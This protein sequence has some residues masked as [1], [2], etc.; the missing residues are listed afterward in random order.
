[1]STVSKEDYIKTIFEYNFNGDENI[2][3][4]DL[5]ASLAI[6]KP[7]VTD[8]VKKLTRENF[9]KKDNLNQIFLT[10]KGENIATKLLRKHRLWEIFLHDVLKLKW[11]EIH[12]E[13]EKLEHSTSDKLIDKLEEFLGFPERDPHGSPIPNKEGKINQTEII[14]QLSNQQ[15]GMHFVKKINDKQRDFIEAL[16]DL[17]INIDSKIEIVKKF[18]FDNSLLIRV[19]KS[20]HLISQNFAERI[21]VGKN[22]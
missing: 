13:A 16:N 20:E 19:G 9:V 14:D 6:S 8:M 15:T 2:K 22:K 4:S 3:S 18:E 7:A 12:E 21:F 5:A 1:M 10:K 17:N 11:E